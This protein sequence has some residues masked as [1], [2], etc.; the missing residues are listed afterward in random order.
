MG[1][2]ITVGTAPK[3]TQSNPRGITFC[4][5]KSKNFVNR[6]AGTGLLVTPWTRGTNSYPIYMLFDYNYDNSI[7]CK[8]I[9]ALKDVST[10]KFGPVPVVVGSYGVWCQGKA[11]SIPEM[12]A[13]DFISSWK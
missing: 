8:N 12:S 7:D 5:F 10:S 2:N 13:G 1:S 6:D 9:S 11:K 3:A 4:E